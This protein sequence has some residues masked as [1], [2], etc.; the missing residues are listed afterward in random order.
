[1]QY[2]GSEVKCVSPKPVKLNPL[3]TG[4]LER[5]GA[6]EFARSKACGDDFK[7]NSQKPYR[8]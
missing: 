1:M 7:R 4:S 3:V 8:V 6:A 5:K 2:R